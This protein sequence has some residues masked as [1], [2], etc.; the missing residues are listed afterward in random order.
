M[1]NIFIIFLL[2]LIQ[3]R[4]VPAVTNSANGIHFQHNFRFFWLLSWLLNKQSQLV[5][6]KL[7]DGA[8]FA[9]TSLCLIVYNRI[10]ESVAAIMIQQLVIIKI[11][12]C[13]FNVD[14]NQYLMNLQT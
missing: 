7:I 5:V 9:M 14:T 8:A 6:V 1:K 13:I 12:Y 2:S 3:F 10:V 11:S 4:F